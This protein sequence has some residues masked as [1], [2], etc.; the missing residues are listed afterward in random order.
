[1]ST[2]KKE[3]KAK[4]A[5]AA[6]TRSI[7]DQIVEATPQTEPDHAKDL[8]T[9]L[10]SQ[11]TEGT[12]TYYKDVTRTLTAAIGILDAKLSRQLASIMHA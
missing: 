3:S 4:E 8:V 7:L 10:V 12:V 5:Q 11:A 9:A 2:G 6:E 1:M